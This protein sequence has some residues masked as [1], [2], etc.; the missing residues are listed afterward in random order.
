MATVTPGTAGVPPA[1]FSYSY[2]DAS[3][4][5]TGLTMPGNL[6]VSRTFDS[7][8]RLASVT[9]QRNTGVPPV[10]FSSFAYTYDAADRRTQVDLVDGG[11]WEYSYDNAGQLTGGTRYGPKLDQQ[12]GTLVQCAYQYDAMGN[13]TQRTEDAAVSPPSHDQRR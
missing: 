2:T 3:G 6:T 7:L 12:E 5:F 1:S 4:Q 9:N 13:P 8:G 11:R 10:V